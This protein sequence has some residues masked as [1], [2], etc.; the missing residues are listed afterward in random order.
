MTAPSRAQNLSA[1]GDGI[2]GCKRLSTDTVGLRCS[3]AQRS[4]L[5]LRLRLRGDLRDTQ[6]ASRGHAQSRQSQTNSKGIAGSC[7]NSLHGCSPPRQQ[8][9]GTLEPTDAINSAPFG[10]AQHRNWRI[11]AWPHLTQWRLRSAGLR[12]PPDP[13]LRPGTPASRAGSS[14]QTAH[15]ISHHLSPG[16]V[17]RTSFL[18]RPFI[19]RVPCLSLFPSLF[20]APEA[21][22]IESSSE[23]TAKAPQTARRHPFIIGLLSPS[24]RIHLDILRV[25]SSRPSSLLARSTISWTQSPP[26]PDSAASRVAGTHRFGAS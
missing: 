7:F 24:V 19:D 17:S 8:V 6:S 14:V 16:P 12:L 13:T 11:L 26:A 1:F 22:L 2:R 3:R 9:A 15:R 25:R 18:L 4:V 10:A 21:I 5:V 23:Q 20:C